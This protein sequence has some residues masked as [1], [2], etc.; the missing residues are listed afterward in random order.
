[1]NRD[2][3]YFLAN[4]LYW[5]ALIPVLLLSLWAQAQVSGSFRRYSAQITAGASPVPRRR[6][7]CSGPV[8]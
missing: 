3:A 2:Y 4:N 1:M 6:R 7:Q 5:V 8:V